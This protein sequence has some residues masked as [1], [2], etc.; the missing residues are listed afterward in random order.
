M[1]ILKM[2]LLEYGVKEI[3]GA[4]HNPTIVKYSK[5][6]GFG[7]VIDDETAWCSIFV[8][9]CAMKV[10]LERSKKL[11]A[12]SWLTIG[13]KAKKPQPGDVV[14][15]W[16]TSPESWKGHVAL[17]INYSEDK[18]FIYCLGGNQQNQVKISAYDAN[19]LLT[20]R[21]LNKLN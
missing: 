8:N 6:I 4:N 19:R 2:A 16:R 9:W 11:N 14:V 15:F 13:E 1:D 7:G 10:G 18:K 21:R 5:D 20:F 17:F 12:R 3:A